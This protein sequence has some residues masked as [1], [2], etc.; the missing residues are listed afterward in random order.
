[1]EKFECN[2]D[3][4]DRS[5]TRARK[6]LEMSLAKSKIK[7]PFSGITSVINTSARHTAVEEVVKRSCDQTPVEDHEFFA[8]Q[9]SSEDVE[10]SAN[11][12]LAKDVKLS[13]AETSAVIVELFAE[14]TYA[15][16]AKLSCDQTP[17]E[18][19]ELLADQTPVEDAELPADKTS[20]EDV[21]L[22]ADQT[23]LEN[24]D[25][26][27]DR[28]PVE[29]VE[30]L[31]DQPGEVNKA[32]KSDSISLIYDN[33]SQEQDF[34]PCVE[35]SDD[36]T[37][38]YSSDIETVEDG[39]TEFSRSSAA[40]EGNSTTSIIQRGTK[41]KFSGGES[42]II[43]TGRKRTRNCESWK[44][45]IRKKNR[46]NGLPYIT[47]SGISVAMKNPKKVNCSK[48]RFHCEEKIN[49]EKRIECC[50]YYYSIA[51]ERKKDFIC[52]NVLTGTVGYRRS[53]G[54]RPKNI[55][56]FYYLAVDGA[57]QRVCQ[58]FFLCNFVNRQEKC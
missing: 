4:A 5:M 56:C 37:I 40:E 43:K 10:L 24:V 13:A 58:K 28:T 7:I 51:D 47:R 12:S 11:Q 1:M 54:I 33:N 36:N 25:W 41:R 3:R 57:A 45:T 39:Q 16:N 14:H 20:V 44:C 48:C 30:L 15:K 49:E 27:P 6:I 32:R 34:I 53:T 19:V 42:D 18:D 9:T 31:C 23:R 50:R 29:V 55:S 8:H 2:R 46:N 17:V 21:E 38:I 26:S 22:P 35:E 52:A